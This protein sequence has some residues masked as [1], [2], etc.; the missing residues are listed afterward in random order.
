[1]LT[2]DL[3]KDQKFIEYIYSMEANEEKIILS[4]YIVVQHFLS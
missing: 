4:L 1:M 3:T 2:S